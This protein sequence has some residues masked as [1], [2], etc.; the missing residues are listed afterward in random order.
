MSEKPYNK[1]HARLS[2]MLDSSQRVREEEIALEML[3]SGNDDT[4]KIAAETGW[5]R[6]RVLQF[7]RRPATLLAIANKH[8][9]VLSLRHRGLA[10]GIVEDLLKGT[11]IAH[12]IGQD[13][14]PIEVVE[15]V[16]AALRL[17]AAKLV[18]K[19]S[20]FEEVMP[21]PRPDG[22][23]DLADMSVEDLHRHLESIEAEIASQAHSVATEEADLVDTPDQK[24]SLNS[25]LD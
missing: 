11:I 22:T 16:P 21:L 1:G 4:D 10:I 19:V 9:A 5:P 8:L 7:R 25:M 14:L 12:D 15:R 18:F 6:E 24:P 17:E 20:R 23:R 2:T 13:G 3:A